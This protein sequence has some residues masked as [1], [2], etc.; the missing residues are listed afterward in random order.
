MTKAEFR[1]EQLYQATMLIARNLH[2]QGLITTK[3]YRQIEAVFKEK[4][5]PIL[6]TLFNDIS[7]T[8]ET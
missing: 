5:N 4:Y 8:Y 7:L 1:N 6:G 3:E 2:S